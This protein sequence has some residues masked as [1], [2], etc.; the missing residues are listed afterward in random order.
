MH[1]TKKLF[2]NLRP[3]IPSTHIFG[4]NLS[5]KLNFFMSL[6]KRPE[7]SS[8]EYHPLLCISMWSDHPLTKPPIQLLGWDTDLLLQIVKPAFPERLTRIGVLYDLWKLFLDGFLILVKLGTTGWL[9]L[10]GYTA[11]RGERFR[12]LRHYLH[13]KYWSVQYI[14]DAGNCVG[15]LGM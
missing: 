2:S 9:G 1:E 6:N 8:K 13:T 12:I 15:L 10:V 3:D 14:C 4:L 7:V 11:I 5:Y